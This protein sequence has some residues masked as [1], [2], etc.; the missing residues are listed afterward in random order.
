[1][2][3]AALFRSGPPSS[4]LETWSEGAPPQ[5]W[6]RTRTV[7]LAGTKLRKRL[8]GKPSG[9]RP[10]PDAQ[11]IPVPPPLRGSLP[12]HRP[13]HTQ[14]SHHPGA[15]STNRPPLPLKQQSLPT[16]SPSADEN[17]GLAFTRATSRI[18]VT[19]QAAA[20]AGATQNEQR[21]P[22][23]KLPQQDPSN[24]CHSFYSISPTPIPASK[25]YSVPSPAPTPN[26][27]S[28]VPPEALA[29]SPHLSQASVNLQ[30]PRPNI[31]TRLTDLTV[32][33]GDGL[34]SA[35]EYRLLR[36]ALLSAAVTAE[37]GS[38]PIQRSASRR[39]SY[40]SAEQLQL[41]PEPK[42][43]RLRCESTSSHDSGQTNASRLFSTNRKRGPERAFPPSA[44]VTGRL[45]KA[46]ASLASLENDSDAEGSSVMN[47]PAPSML[48]RGRSLRLRR[49]RSQRSVP[50]PRP[51]S[52]MSASSTG[53]NGQG[54]RLSRKVEQANK[55]QELFERIQA[56]RRMAALAKAND[57]PRKPK[58]SFHAQAPQL[59]AASFKSPA[60][61]RAEM[62][63]VAA[64]QGALLASIDE[65][66]TQRG[67][68]MKSQVNRSH[69]IC[70]V[71][72]PISNGNKRAGHSVSSLNSAA[73]PE[74]E[75]SKMTHSA[76][77]N[78]P[79][80]AA[81]RSI[82]GTILSRKPSE[83]HRRISSVPNGKTRDKDLP[84]KPGKA[85]R[86][87]P[88]PAHASAVTSAFGMGEQNV[89]P[90]P[91]S[92]PASGVMPAVAQPVP[93]MPSPTEQD[94][95]M[96]MYARVTER[97]EERLATLRSSLRSAQLREKARR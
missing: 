13:R 57:V 71:F 15:V 32:A 87:A 35:D 91:Q 64:E 88:V 46:N 42:L 70:T 86:A 63:I 73:T 23:P 66:L 47:G 83:P 16:T 74:P 95:L 55:Q 38:P 60:E 78:F 31:A 85:D 1:M 53:S 81:R 6:S 37:G 68:P 48:S 56:D 25:S 29:C 27:P 76:S 10:A 82:F 28:P 80:S 19:T 7:S 93:A 24:R 84:S 26:H 17:L 40:D 89:V 69:S 9:G 67:H 49:H 92:R 34:L 72:R 65:A 2:K 21:L 45:G 33:H 90:F 41:T 59:H 8:S 5:Q 20:A 4:D 43:A 44:S 12:A 14:A 61:I 18:H 22:L 30:P 51:K 39:S 77:G 11:P 96:L 52:V 3:L 97:Y 58:V 50:E 75:T 94:A 62:E 79:P 54:K 36:S